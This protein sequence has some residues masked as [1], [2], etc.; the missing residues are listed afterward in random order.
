MANKFF[1]EFDKDK[2]FKD[3]STPSGPSIKQ[4]DLSLKEKTAAWP[5]LPGKAQSKDRSAGIKR[6]KIHPKSVGI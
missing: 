3:R 6:A 5:G 4:P 1:S 2:Q